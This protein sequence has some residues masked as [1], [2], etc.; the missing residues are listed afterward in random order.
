MEEKGIGR[1]STY[2]P[3]ISTI[4]DREYVVKES[5]YLRPTVL[6]EVVTELMEARFPD[7]VDLKFTARME[8]TLDD[9]EAGK[10]HWKDLLSEFYGNFDNEL[11]EAE[12]AL[13]GQ[14][15]KIPDE[16][17][18][19]ICDKCG[20]QMVVKT[21]RFGRFLACPGYPECDFTKPLVIEMPG[22]CPKCGG[23]ILKRTSKKG[24]AYYACEK[25]ADCG[26]MT[27]DVPVKEN[28]PE[29]GK[30]LFKLSG[31]GRKTPFCINPECA[32]FL[33]EDKRGY[34][35][36]A[37][38]QDK[39]TGKTAPDDKNAPAKTSAAKKAAPA[40]TSAA[41]KA[42]PAKAS[43]AKKA[44][45]AKASAAKKAVPAKTSVAKKAAPAKTS[46]AKKAA[47]AKTS[48]AKK[49]VPAKTSVAKKAAPA[50]TSAAKKAASAKTS[51]AKKAVPAKAPAAKKDE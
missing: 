38:A 8:E 7:I 24:Y 18:D 31:K 16:V 22:K 42:A 35:K 20:R 41:K 48:A 34:R 50:K 39:E 47:P 5:K 32:N 19:E 28:C 30:T 4:T 12:K 14:H 43:A 51:A 15:I 1:P 9:V 45:P 11:Q 13:D 2:A 36:T 40:K 25:G 27:W 10:R 3:T 29:C 33:P 37:A 23:R 21:G 44:V 46:A 17:S 6:G 26:F 49:A